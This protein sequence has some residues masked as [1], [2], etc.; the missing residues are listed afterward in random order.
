MTTSLLNKNTEEDKMSDIKEYKCP[1]CGAPLKY[2]IETKKMVC[3]FCANTYDLD[4]VRNNFNE[5]T[6]E[7]SD[8][9][10]WIKQTQKID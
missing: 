10:D 4:Y 5:P 3:I 7:K 9:F 2:N 8:N 6:S 1:N